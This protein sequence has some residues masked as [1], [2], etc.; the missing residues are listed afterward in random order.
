MI[1]NPQRKMTIAFLSNFAG[2]DPYAVA[3]ALFEALPDFTCTNQYSKDESVRLCWYGHLFCI[4]RQAACFFMNWGAYLGNCD[5]PKVE[6]KQANTVTMQK[7]IVAQTE[8]AV[9]MTAYPNPF[10]TA[11]DL[12]FRATQ[13]GRAILRVYDGTGKLVTTLFDGTVQKDGT[14]KI[15]LQAGNLSNGIYYSQLQTTQGITRQKLVLQ[16]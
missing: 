16:R 1:Y 11:V 12:S 4:P 13:S 14:Q 10:R 15:T 9:R 5:V 3:K 8:P 7:N 2:I 6:Y